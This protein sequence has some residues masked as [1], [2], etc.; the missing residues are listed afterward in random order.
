MTYRCVC[1][2]A[3]RELLVTT[4]YN[5]MLCQFAALD[6]LQQGF[7]LSVHY[8]VLAVTDV[9]CLACLF[10]DMSQNVSVRLVRY[11]SYLL[12]ECL[13]DWLM[14]LKTFLTK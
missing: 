3:P 6:F 9:L 8:V 4:T 7:L 14:Q 1:G 13:E 12:L 5:V 2:I 11:F 10:L